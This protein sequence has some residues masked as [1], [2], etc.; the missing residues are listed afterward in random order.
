[1]HELA[2][3]VCYW[4]SYRAATGT[5]DLLT[6][7]SLSIPIAES[8]FFHRWNI[9]TE[10]DYHEIF[11][12][13]ASAKIY[14]DFYTERSEERLALETKF[15]KVSCNSRVFNDILRLGLADPNS[16]H[17]VLLLAWSHS[18]K[19]KASTKEFRR[20]LSLKKGETFTIDPV[21]CVFEC[22]DLSVVLNANRSDFERLRKLRYPEATSK[23]QG[24][25]ADAMETDAYGA[26]E[27][28]IAPI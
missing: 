3:A 24:T 10:K 25:C 28:S 12:S 21:Q 2:G 14:T 16:I 9:G 20:L 13:I 22:G 5:A 4:L 8:L 6:E 18:A 26:A 11:P 1:M 27:Y 23:V 19:I 15:F 17:R 7:G